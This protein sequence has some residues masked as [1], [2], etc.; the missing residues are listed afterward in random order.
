M[1]IIAQR[2]GTSAGGQIHGSYVRGTNTV[3]RVDHGLLP[4]GT[5][6][7][8]NNVVDTAADA[9]GTGND[10]GFGSFIIRWPDATVSGTFSYLADATHCELL[11]TVEL[12]QYHRDR[13]ARL[14]VAATAVPRSPPPTGRA[15]VVFQRPA[16]GSRPVSACH[17]HVMSPGSPGVCAI[18]DAWWRSSAAAAGLSRSVDSETWPSGRRGF[19][20]R[21]KA[22]LWSA[23]S[24][25]LACEDLVR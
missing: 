14:G 16:S 9:G 20:C 1:R 18:V 24:R 6:T 4:N 23:L 8:A 11:A 2:P 7:N 19:P 21:T 17:R 13:S 12:M 3:Q 10:S 22:K 5:V 25:L 15:R